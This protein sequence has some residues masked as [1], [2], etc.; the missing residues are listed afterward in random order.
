M[1]KKG[2][3]VQSA[4]QERLE[5][6]RWMRRLTEK[7]G[8][9]QRNRVRSRGRVSH[10]LRGK[11]PIKAARVEIE[12][13]QALCLDKKH[14]ETCAFIGRIREVVRS[15]KRA[16]LVFRDVQTVRTSALM[17]LVSQIHRLRFEHGQNCITGT[18]PDNLGVERLMAESGF[19]SLL[20]IRTRERVQK[21]SRGRRYI[22]FRSGTGLAGTRLKE[23]REEI[24]QDD[25]LMSV[26]VRHKIFRAISE[27]ATNVGHHAYATKAF[28]TSA[29]AKDL[30]GRWWLL[31]SLN[32]P[33]NLFTLVFSDMG[34][35]IPKTLPRRYPI[36]QVRAA[37]SLLP[38][39]RVDDGQMIEAAMVLGRTRTHLDNRGKG[40]LDLTQLIDLLG[41]GEMNI[42]SRHGVVTYASGA[43]K[44]KNM[45][46][47]IEG[48]LIEWKLPLDKALVA[49]VPGSDDEAH[50]ED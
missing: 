9:N 35:G 20:G 49:Q 44:V 18:Y 48:T 8:R 37:L 30:F 34:V 31:A 16:S 24:L 45:V 25:F 36:E 4:I 7:E 11:T 12:V 1:S 42:Y 3:A 27:A 29:A 22:Q 13:P 26:Q 5:L 2:G 39:F 43:T 33:R 28:V 46:G 38:G 32:R 10:K 50:I 15:G 14:G 19:F 41:G 23:V 6:R 40:L 21:P 47:L 17:Y